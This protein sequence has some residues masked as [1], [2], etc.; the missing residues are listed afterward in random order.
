MR[1][2]KMIKAPY[3]IVPKAPKLAIIATT[4]FAIANPMGVDWSMNK[5]SSGAIIIKFPST[6]YDLIGPAQYNAPP[7]KIP[8]V[9]IFKTWYI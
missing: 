6:K 3:K 4:P 7:R 1:I 8:A 5:T 9:Y 2:Q